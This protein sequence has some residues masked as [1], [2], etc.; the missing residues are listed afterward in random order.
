V[1]LKAVGRALTGRDAGIMSRAAGGGIGRAA[2]PPRRAYFGPA[3]GHCDTPVITRGDLETGARLGPLII[4]EYD[5][6]CVVPPDAIAGLG[7]HGNIDIR[8]G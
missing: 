7:E 2:V 8:I 5:A 4:E 6:T 3:A 1:S